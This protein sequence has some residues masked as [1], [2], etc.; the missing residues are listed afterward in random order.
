MLFDN[1]LEKMLTNIPPMECLFM[2]DREENTHPVA[3]RGNE[4]HL[5]VHTHCIFNGKKLQRLF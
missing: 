1:C 5:N 2:L 3:K 4:T